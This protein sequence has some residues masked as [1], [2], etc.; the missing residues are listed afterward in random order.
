MSLFQN[1]Y[2]SIEEAWGQP[3]FSPSIVNRYKTQAPPQPLA[4]TPIGPAE[5]TDEAV[6]RRLNET[7]RTKGIAGVKP[8]LDAAIIRD[9]Q[10]DAIVQRYNKPSAAFESIN[11]SREDWMYVLLGLFA[12]LFAMDSS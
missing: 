5:A 2:A 1:Q 12:I 6:I 9:I 10:S 8:L 7:Y 3:I 4:A 11:L